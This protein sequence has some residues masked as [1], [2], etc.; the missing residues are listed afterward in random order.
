MPTESDNMPKE[1]VYMEINNGYGE[2]IRHKHLS[3]SQAEEKL[4]EYR[5]YFGDGGKI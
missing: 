1:N 3:I 2:I 4:K 5:K